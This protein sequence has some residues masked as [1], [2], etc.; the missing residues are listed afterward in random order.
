MED[1]ITY[2]QIRKLAEAISLSKMESIMGM[3]MDFDTDIIE[4]IKIDNFYKS[5]R[6]NIALLKCWCESGDI[7]P[8]P[9]KV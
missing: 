2:Q 9:R 7:G 5:T 6:S 8:R 4:G 1:Q 3:Y